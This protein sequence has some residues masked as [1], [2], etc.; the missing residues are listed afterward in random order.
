MSTTYQTDISEATDGRR[1]VSVRFRLQS[2]QADAPMVIQTFRLYTPD[3][4]SVK[5]G[6]HYLGKDPQ[7]T[8]HHTQ[9]PHQQREYRIP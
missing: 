2:D 6:T 9:D 1:I 5:A 8:E 4:F 7:H 3:D